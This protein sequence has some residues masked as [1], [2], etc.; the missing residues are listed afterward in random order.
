VK[1]RIVLIT[2]P[3]FDDDTIANCIEASARALPAGALCVQLRDKGRL[4]ESLRLWAWRLRLFTRRTG[5]GLVINGDAILA[6]DVGADGVHLGGGAGS[7]RDARLL[8]GPGAWISLAA[9][10]DGDVRRAVDEG[11]D[12]ALV[13]PIYATRPPSSGAAEKQPRG[14]DALRSARSVAMGHVALYALG[15]VT[16]ERV[17]PCAEAGADGVAVLRALLVSRDPGRLARALYDAMAM[18]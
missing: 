17:R 5:A 9:H 4:P 14:L 1:P 2:D 18:R 6:R 12:A 8:L 16:L 11:A 13:S 7:V 15:G 3:A 10:S